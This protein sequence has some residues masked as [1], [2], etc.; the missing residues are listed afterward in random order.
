MIVFVLK[1]PACLTYRHFE[2]K[3]FKYV[4]YHPATHKTGISN[5]HSITAG[6]DFLVLLSSSIPHEPLSFQEILKE[7]LILKNIKLDPLN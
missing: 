3:T 5:G 2:R 1:L 4:S 6:K 7:E